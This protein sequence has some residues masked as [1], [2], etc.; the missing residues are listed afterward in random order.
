MPKAQLELT[1]PIRIRLGYVEL[2]NLSFGTFERQHKPSGHLFNPSLPPLFQPPLSYYVLLW[3]QRTE[4]PSLSPLPELPLR[5]I[6]MPEFPLSLTLL[7][8][9]AKEAPGLTLS[10]CFHSLSP[11]L[12]GSQGP[13]CPKTHRIPSFYDLCSWP[14]QAPSPF[15]SFPL[16]LQPKLLASVPHLEL[17]LPLHL[18]SLPA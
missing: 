14:A 3:T 1:W 12:G 13:S 6:I 4:E 2:I 11:K 15:L 17:S 9:Q 16:W 10:L 5:V 7:E 8:T 18:P